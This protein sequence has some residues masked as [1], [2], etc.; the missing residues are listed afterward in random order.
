LTWSAETEVG[1]SIVPVRLRP[2]TT[3]FSQESKEPLKTR[4]PPKMEDEAFKRLSTGNE[5]NL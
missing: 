5:A 1:V 2:V 3:T 4:N